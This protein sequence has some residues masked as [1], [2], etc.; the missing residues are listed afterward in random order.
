MLFF[1]FIVTS[2][3]LN[4]TGHYITFDV[5]FFSDFMFLLLVVRFD[6]LIRPTL[7]FIYCYNFI[8]PSSITSG[9]TFAEIERLEAL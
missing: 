5:M 9:F 7:S 2:Q 8:Y 3:Q 1:A 4:V 6:E